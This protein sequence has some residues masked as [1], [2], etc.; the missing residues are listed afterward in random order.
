MITTVLTIVGFVI[1]LSSLV[2]I[3]KMRLI[4][5]KFHQR[6]K[7]SVPQM[8]KDLP[9]VSVCIPVRNEEHAMTHCLEEVLASRYPKMEVLVC[10]D[11]SVD[12]T[13]SLI[14]MFARDGVRFIEGPKPIDGWLGKN[15]AL[16][17]LLGEAS[18][19]YVLFLDVDTRIGTDTIG[20]MIAYA[21]QT[22]A[23]M[24]SALP[25]RTHA[26]RFSVWLAPLRYFWRLLIH[27]S[28]RPIAV[29]AI[30]LINRR[31]FVAKYGDMSIIKSSTEPECETAKLFASEGKYRFLI[32]HNLLGVRYE[33]KLSSQLETSVRLCFPSLGFSVWR[34]FLA[35]I[36]LLVYV[37]LPFSLLVAGNTVWAICASILCIIFGYI[38]YLQYLWIVWRRGAVFAALLLPALA[39]LEVAIIMQSVLAYRRGQV[40]WK[41]RPIKLN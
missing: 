20:Q 26:W 13:P 11:S 37:A 3:I 34:S 5:N 4:I 22:G 19:R 38:L 30:W 18:G 24:V 21:E 27:T 1:A 25:L 2:G 15:A 31:E 16:N 10:D 6:K 29:S 28:K 7:V 40:T 9:S 23:N 12:K 39:I 33:K 32:S 14:K 36:G 8:M 41:G 17:K 35:V